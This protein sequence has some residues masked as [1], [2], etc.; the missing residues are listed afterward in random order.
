MPALDEEQDKKLNPAEKRYGGDHDNLGVH[1]ERREAEVDDLE[2]LYNAESAPEPSKRSKQQDSESEKLQ[3]NNSEPESNWETNTAK[4]KK[5]RFSRKK[6]AAGG[7]GA[8][9]LIGGSMGFLSFLAGPLQ[10]IHYAQNLDFFHF[11]DGNDFSNSRVLKLIRWARTDAQDR[12]MGRI[13]NAVARHYE[14]KLRGA[15]ISFEYNNSS[16]RISDIV[17]NPETD[18]GRKLLAQIE[19]D[20]G[21]ELPRE[22]GKVPLNF[23]D[24][25]GKEITD[26]ATRKA[27]VKAAAKALGMN[28]VSQTLAAR[29]LTKRAG[30]SWH[31]LRNRVDNL[32]EK[33]WAK[34]KER[35]EARNKKLKSNEIDGPNKVAAD[36]PEEGK[37][38]SGEDVASG[39]RTAGEADGVTKTARA[40]APSQRPQ[41]VEDIRGN[42]RKGVGVA[43]VITL[44]CG[45]YKLGDAVKDIQEQNIVGPLIRTGMEV[46]TVGNQV[47][48]GQDIDMADLVALTDKFYSEKDGTSFGA[49]ESWQAELGNSDTGQDIP[50]SARP[51]KEKPVFF[52]TVDSVVDTIHAGP[53]CDL[54]TSTVGTITV[55]VAGL[56]AALASGPGAFALEGASTA[57]SEIFSRAFM[58]DLLRWIAGDMV[59]VAEAAG[60]KF[61][62]FATYGAFFAANNSARAMGGSNLSRSEVAALRVERQETMKFEQKQ[63]SLY[64]RI[65][66]PVEPNSLVASTVVA[67][68]NLISASSFAN[69]L[70]NY[71]ANIFS[72][73][74]N[75][76]RSV[77]PGAYA[78]VE[79]F[80]YGIDK[81]GF[82]IDEREGAIEDPYENA[83]YVESLLPELNEKYGKACF[84]TT[85]DPENGKLS[86]E[87]APP[88]IDLPDDCDRTTN[89]DPDFLRYRFYLADVTTLKTMSCYES[90]DE[91]S[92]AE[93]GYS[94]SGS[95]NSSSSGA[96]TNLA[97]A[98]GTDTSAQQCTIGED[99]GIQNTPVAGIKIRVCVLEGIDYNVAI[100]QNVKAILDGARAA[101]INFS[102]SGGFRSYDEQVDLRK[103]NG[104]ADIYTAPSSTCSP[105]TAIPGTSMHEWGLALDLSVNESTI[106]SGSAGYNWMVENEAIHGLKNLPGEPW[107]WSTTGG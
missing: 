58:D 13:G 93:L 56:A 26:R 86:F 48:S 24:D 16:N 84:G 64:A 8:G 44:A 82:S 49:A 55:T 6:A 45:V 33:F 38:P 11:N 57:A 52:K 107:H 87:S 32:D 73:L 81:Y 104:C 67:N 39:S 101:G 94:S 7:L 88:Y 54:V 34:V 100:E 72:G 65:L 27:I 59:D 51:S 89:S 50:E 17:I 36:T 1:P 20:V 9:L 19:A 95:S 42:L 15:G 53:V 69:S 4:P 14:G 98:K 31:P 61:G 3:N 10:V 75:S 90:V 40:A 23:V 106:K 79:P 30:V 85:V 63:K 78:Q 12:N 97:E 83:E 62:G 66:N 103:T 28:K 70:S 2:R 21:F 18:A 22:N 37:T 105:A 25:A 46:I 41:L 76:I 29:S 99:G 96:N 43:G 35:K 5:R 68:P 74:G 60:A 71:P 92:C 91:S 80:D 47:M 77:L 102:G